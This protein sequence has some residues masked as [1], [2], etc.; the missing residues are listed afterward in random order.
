MTPLSDTLKWWS[1]DTPI[2]EVMHYLNDLVVRGKVL[3]LG[4]SDTPAWIV[5]RANQCT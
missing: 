2:E 5:S 4:I 3:Y 1:Y